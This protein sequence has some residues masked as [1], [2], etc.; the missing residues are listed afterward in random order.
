M[1]RTPEADLER[2]VRDFL[3]LDGW[4]ALKTDPVS[5]REWGKGFGELGIADALYI[6]YGWAQSQVML[7]VMPWPNSCGSSGKRPTRRAAL[8]QL[9]WHAREQA[10]GAL[11]LIAGVDFLAT[12]EGFLGWYKNSGLQ[13]RSLR[14][15]ATKLRSATPALNPATWQDGEVFHSE[16][17]HVFGLNMAA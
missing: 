14:I 7:P 8:H 9:A 4:R 2:A 17:K 11:A 5:R 10:R 16:S 12:F 6:R 13:R 1:K 15:A 3:A